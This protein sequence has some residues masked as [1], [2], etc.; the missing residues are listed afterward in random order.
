MTTTTAPRV[1]SNDR[2]F[3]C[4][5]GTVSFRSLMPATKKCPLCK[6]RYRITF[7]SA[8][9]SERMGSVVWHAVW[10]PAEAAA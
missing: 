10:S 2:K 4:C 5:G 8:L 3:P 1:L 6:I 9:V 7:T